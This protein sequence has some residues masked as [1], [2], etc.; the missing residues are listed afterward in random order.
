MSIGLS[1]PNL[2]K[3]LQNFPFKAKDYPQDKCRVLLQ[4]TAILDKYENAAKNAIYHEHAQKEKAALEK[5]Y[6]CLRDNSL[7]KLTRSVDSYPFFTAAFG[8]SKVIK[9]FPTFEG[10]PTPA[11]LRS[12]VFIKQRIDG[13]GLAF[14]LYV[15]DSDG[16]NCYE[17]DPP[18]FCEKI[19]HRFIRI[20]RF[21]G[22]KL[23]SPTELSLN[24]ENYTKLIEAVKKQN[25]RIYNY[26]SICL[27]FYRLPQ[28]LSRLTIQYVRG[29]I[30]Q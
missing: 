8:G 30:Y 5:Q 13:L 4:Y 17:L 24:I 7:L 25:K 3:S 6:P 2:P 10:T 18:S 21:D 19:H 11:D 12:H 14:K 23:T 20:L 28:P 27:A 29:Y 26:I 9:S 1:S 16:E 22:D 15:L